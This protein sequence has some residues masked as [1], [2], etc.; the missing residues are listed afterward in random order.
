MI[1]LF[2][3]FFEKA[4]VFISFAKMEYFSGIINFF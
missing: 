1:F 2:Y 3:V 4:F